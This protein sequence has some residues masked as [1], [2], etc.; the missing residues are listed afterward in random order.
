MKR[1]QIY[2]QEKQR[3]ELNK[4]ASRNGKAMAEMIREAIDMYIVESKT[5]TKDNILESS[6]LW[7]DRD[8]IDTNEY[9]NSIR[10]GLDKRLEDLLK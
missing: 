2:L 5:K 8:D 6:G 9:T 4:L 3:E 7:K 1:T 10:K